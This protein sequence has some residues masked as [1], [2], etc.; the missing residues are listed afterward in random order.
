MKVLYATH[1]LLASSLPIKLKSEGSE[2]IVF[3]EADL[4]TLEGLVTKM[5]FDQLKTEIA[6]LD[7]EKDLI[8]F[9][10]CDFGDIPVKLRDKG[11]NVIGG[12]EKTDK[13]EKDRQLGGKIAELAGLK[14]PQMHKIA[15]LKEGIQFVKDKPQRYAL[16]Q[17]G[18]IDDIKGLNHLSKLDDGKDLINQM[19]W[20]DKRWV[21]GLKQDFILQEFVD[22]H[23]VAMGAYFN[24]KEFMKDKDG[25][26]ICEL[27]FE[28]KALAVGDRGQATGEMFTLIKFCKAKDCKLFQETLEK[29]KPIL[30]KLNYRGCIDIN[31]IIKDGEVYFLEFTNRFGSPATSGHLP[32]MKGKWSD[33]LYAM[34]RGEQIDFE[35]DSRWLIVAMLVTAPFPSGNDDKIR[36]LIEAKYEKTPPKNDD[37]RKE[38]L[39]VRLVDSLDQIILFK[40]QPTKEEMKMINLDYVY[41]DGELKVSNSAG[42]AVTVN[43]LGE[44]PKEAG[45]K[46]EKLLKKFILPKSFWRNDWTSHYDKSK[47][48]LIKWGYL[49]DDSTVEEQLK[50]KEEQEAKNKQTK[51]IEEKVKSDYDKKLSDIKSAVKG[52]IYADK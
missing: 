20:L 27:N 7:K 19:E 6:K 18:K 13:M 36:T 49:Q 47:K 45:E 42:Y 34:A 2:V 46:V 44:T 9:E 30:L 50:A 32:L 4:K 28:H 48:D 15:S 40:E 24:G 31:S 21:K 37:E 14:V 23:E 22:G 38:L 16:K 3:E 52:I 41:K 39:D 35:I 43:G 29:I 8:I 33:F 11:Y 26:E 10:D 5:P 1:D 25:D 17:Q 51:D 12:S